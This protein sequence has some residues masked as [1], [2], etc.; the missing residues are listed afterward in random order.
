M[1]LSSRS[2]SSS[3]SCL[4]TGTPAGFADFVRDASDEAEADGFPPLDREHDV[5]RLVEAG[6]RFGIELLGPAGRMP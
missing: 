3:H 5:S 1:G 4:V 6:A 2:T